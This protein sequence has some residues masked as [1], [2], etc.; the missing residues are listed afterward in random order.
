MDGQF[1][2]IIVGS[3]S[4]GSV[5]AD[6][7]SQDGRKRVLVLE[8]G[9]SD[10]RFFVHMPLGY[11]KLFY[12]PAVNWC[13]RT[14]PDPGLNG[15]RDF[16]P[17]G[18][19]MGG[20]S[21]IN[22]M[23]WIRGHR[24]DY[25]DWQ[26]IGGADWGW[27][28][29]LAAYKALEDNEAGGDEW[30]G[31]GGPLFI[32]ANRRHGHPLVENYL[33][34]CEAAGLP[35]NTDFN[36]A[37]QDGAG[38][39][40]LTIKGARRN[41]AARAFLRPAL[42]RPN[43]ALRTHA[44]VTRVLLEGRRA[45]G[46]EYRWKGAVHQ[47]RGAEVILSGGAINTPQILMLSGIGPA[48]HL[49]DMGVDV[50]LDQPNVGAH[51]NDHQGINYTWKMKV[52]TLNQQL[53]PWWGKLWAGMQYMLAGQ[54]PLAV[55][56]NHAGGFFRT[57]PDM[58]RPNMQL[59]MQAFSTLIPREGERPILSPDPFAGLSLGLSNCRPSSRGHI[60]LASADP[61]AA[62]KITAN[63][64]STN[65]DVAEMLDA[66]KMLR[67][68]AAQPALAQVIDEELRPG[69]DIRDDAA[70]IDDF[71]ARSGTVFHP[72]CTARM[73]ADAANSVV[74]SKLRVHGIEGLRVCDA[75]SFPTLIGGN[76]NA[77][78]VLMGWIGADLIGKD[79][80]G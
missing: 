25:D 40:Q 42:K 48:D 27:D 13:Y 17:R 61:F 71:K 23:V 51:L 32:S 76:T 73:G 77:P 44:H 68:I 53:R 63:V 35:R 78:A 29:A 15:Q 46:V 20:S 72:S 26:A 56:I 14:E 3:G 43:V 62:P 47:A 74:D 45:V 6:R 7:L 37:T 12:D 31:A 28:A 52:P 59:Y 19:V 22:A 69:P 65:E 5:L 16:W 38:T 24:S 30:R 34:A 67:K 80:R 41:S 58:T 64:F 50:V 49:C 75:S 55:S 60:R 10:R 54:G 39:Y 66:V 57:S 33:Q 11:G 70:L 79:G 36:G 8:A 4:A 2:Y 1:D 9:G 18:K 21:S